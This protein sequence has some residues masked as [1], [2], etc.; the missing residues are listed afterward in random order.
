V[1]VLIILSG[2]IGMV[3]ERAE[4]TA[5]TREAAEARIIA[6]KIAQSMEEAYSGGE[7]HCIIVKM[8]PAIAGMSYR[9]KIN[10]SRVLVEI[11]NRNCFSTSSV[12]RVTGQIYTEQILL[13]PDCTYNITHQR[14]ENEYHFFVINEV[15]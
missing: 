14:D 8:P 7:G 5:I 4:T 12:P 3:E 6:E 10:S 9:V 1:V 2:I 11:N 13:Y 15:T